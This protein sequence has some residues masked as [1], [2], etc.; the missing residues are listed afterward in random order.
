M[1]FDQKIVENNLF[2]LL[3]KKQN[4]GTRRWLP[5]P[6]FTESAKYIG[7]P[8][9]LIIYPVNKWSEEQQCWLVLTTIQYNAMQY[10]YG[11]WLPS[12]LISWHLSIG[13]VYK[14]CTNSPLSF[15]RFM[16]HNAM[17]AAL[18]HNN[19]M[20]YMWDYSV[21]MEVKQR[22]YICENSMKMVCIQ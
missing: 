12:P 9:D 8:F 18:K 5:L 4:Y 10:N 1:V 19:T 13:Q 2:S 15:Q 14:D 3:R 6:I 17:L 16:A 11:F 7:E 21:T 20:P 22:K